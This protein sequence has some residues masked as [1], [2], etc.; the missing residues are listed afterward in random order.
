MM[1]PETQFLRLFPLQAMVL[2]PRAEL[3][4]VV[5]EPRYVQLIQECT[6]ANEPFGVLLLKEGREVGNNPVD[7]FDV[8]TTAH[9]LNTSS[10]GQGRLSV[11]AVGGQRFRAHSF[12]RDLPYLSA[13]VEFLEDD[14]A[15]AV[16]PSLAANVRDDAIALVRAMM[17]LRGGFVGNVELSDE[18]VALS[19]EVAQ[20]FQGNPDIQQKLLKRDTADRLAEER[21]LLKNARTQMADRSRRE[22]P[23][24]SFSRN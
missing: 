3:P 18:P 6:E 20:L 13:Q 5:F 12:G 17:A 10:M 4:L 22:G 7:P 15:S 23:G 24:S 2:F 9:I 14:T 16:E 21:E 19:Y 8:G 11:T 1:Q